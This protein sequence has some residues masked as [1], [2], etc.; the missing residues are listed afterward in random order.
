MAAKAQNTLKDP[1]L[2][3][4]QSEEEIQH[5]YIKYM[6]DS[7]SVS[8]L[9]VANAVPNGIIN[10]II[11]CVAIEE[12]EVKRQRDISELLVTE[13]HY[14]KILRHYEKHYINE[15]EGKS[16]ILSKEQYDVLCPKDIWRN[17]LTLHTVF[18]D[19]LHDE[20]MRYSYWNSGISHVFE[21]FMLPYIHIYESYI[22]HYHEHKINEVVSYENRMDRSLYSFMEYDMECASLKENHIMAQSCWVYPLSRLPRYMLILKSMQKHSEDGSSRKETLGR[23]LRRLQEKLTNLNEILQ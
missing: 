15:L 7:I 19:Q 3:K 1:A 18:Y 9:V 10:I 20:C 17:L 12:N 11:D 21:D 16:K 4:I 2:F 13:S 14:I 22:N 23:V 5:C 6:F 8:T